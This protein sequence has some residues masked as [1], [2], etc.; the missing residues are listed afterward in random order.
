MQVAN[1]NVV[2][3]ALW[4][5]MHG[6]VVVAVKICSRYSYVQKGRSQDAKN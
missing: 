6:K 5:F 3:V 4:P 2:A 1:Y